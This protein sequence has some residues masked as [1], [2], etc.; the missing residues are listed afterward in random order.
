MAPPKRNASI[1]SFFPRVP[2]ASV[3]NRPKEDASSAGPAPSA[4]SST[5]NPQTSDAELSPACFDLDTSTVTSARTSSHTISPDAQPPSTSQ[6]SVTSA[7]SKRVISNGE[8]VVRDSDSDSDSLKELD[9]GGTN[10]TFKT[11]LAPITRSKRTTDYDDDG[12]RRP[13]RRVRSKK[14]QYDKVI[15]AAQRSRELERIITEHKVNL[16]NDMEETATSELVINEDALGQ[17][18]QDDDDPDRAHRLLLA[19]QRTDA[20]H[21]DSVFHFFH[22]SSPPAQIRPTFPIN[23]PTR[24]QAFL[25]GFA[26]QVFRL[27][28]LPEELA[29]W[30]ISEI[31]LNQ[32]GALNS[33]YIDILETHNEHLRSLLDRNRLDDIF[34]N[35]GAE[36][37]SLKA[38][39]EL[40]PNISGHSTSHEAISPLL[41]SIANLLE[42]AA[43][44]L[45]TK[46]RSHALHILCYTCLDD[47]VLADTN[48]LDA[49]QHAIEALICNF[50]D[51]HKLIQGVGNPQNK[52]Q[53]QSLIASQLSDLLPPLLAR[54]THPYLQQN[55]VNALPAN[56]PVTAYFRRHLALSF[57]LHPNIVEFPLAHP[58]IPLLIHEHLETSLDFCI[59]KETN[60]RFF[61][62][63]MTLLDIAIGPGPVSVPYQPLVSP[64][65]SRPG[66]PS[67]AP[68]FPASNQVKKF[69][70]EVDAL[71]QHIKL[72]GNSIMEADAVADLT[73]LEAKDC[74]ERLCARLEHAVRIGGKKTYD[75]FGTDDDDDNNDTG[76]QRNL[77]DMFSK[78]ARPRANIFDDN[79]TMDDDCAVG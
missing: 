22:G 9:F 61:V 8:Q 42:R 16:E 55:L 48:T 2:P 69:N 36:L 63:R 62:A 71:S 35:I 78:K 30:M 23:A 46:A 58:Q 29:H 65:S 6:T 14:Q 38:E 10:V 52:D 20:T 47:R 59:S 7:T 57:L 53:A 41:Q 39:S 44:F 3:P 70:K 79:D 33:K 25:T 72:V 49:V 45:R 43:P 60:Y 24:D 67:T 64:A 17:A 32:S 31:C 50:V 4:H 27:R 12:L 68:P 37:K 13:E 19:M 73:I 54:V 18:V 77:K 21:V 5:P 15:Q 34:A 74:V 28:D 56:S 75:M 11:T 26:R 51:N 66:S 40:A 76:K 1:L